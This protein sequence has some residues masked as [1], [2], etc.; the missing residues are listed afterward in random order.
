MA[1]VYY[2]SL[3]LFSLYIAHVLSGNTVRG[4]AETIFL[5]YF[6]SGYIYIDIYINKIYKLLLLKVKKRK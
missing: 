1:P 2:I 3:I 5:F 4:K 6:V